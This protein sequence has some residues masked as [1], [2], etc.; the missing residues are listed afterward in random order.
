MARNALIR[1]INAADC[2]LMAQAFAAQGWDKPATQYERYLVESLSGQRMVLIAEV[3]RQ[4]AGYLTIVWFSDYLPFR[5]AGI[6]EIVDFNVLQKFQRQGIG[7]MLMNKAE[8][9]I[10]A[11]SSKAGIGVGLTA[12]YGA[13][14]ILYVRRGYIPDGQGAISHNHSLRYGEAVKV[15]DGLAL[16]LT[17]ELISP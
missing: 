15:D 5:T 11:V 3:D 2:E 14:Q 9:R 17:K 13:A 4:F 1:E 10:A 8:Q 7:S 16:Y 12:D 6:P